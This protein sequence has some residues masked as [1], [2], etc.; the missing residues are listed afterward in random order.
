M[1]AEAYQR[2][3]QGPVITGSASAVSISALD[4]AYGSRAVLSGLNLD[5]SAGSFVA[6]VGES[7]CGKSTLLRLIAGLDSPS[8]GV[9][10]INGALS[11]GICGEIRMMFQDSR[12]FPWKRVDRNVGLGL[13]EDWHARATSVLGEVGLADRAGD[14][15]SVLSGGQRQRV[16]LARALAGNPKILLLDEPLGALDALTRLDMQRLIERVWLKRGCTVLLITHDVEEAIALA[17]RVL[18]MEGGR[19]TVD[20]SV[21]LSRP[22]DRANGEFIAQKE[23]LLGR[24]LKE[25]RDRHEQ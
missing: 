19:I 21:T 10:E 12:L 5:I 24:L 16:A 20:E 15:P 2:E 13:A 22:R 25:R 4:K 6:L 14:W 3:E 9:I 8:G 17:D 18:V 7:G 23:R 1:I 11:R